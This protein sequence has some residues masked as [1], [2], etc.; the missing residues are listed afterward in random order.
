MDNE[1]TVAAIQGL[2]QD[3]VALSESRLPAVEKLCYDLENNIEAFRTLLEKKPKSEA[4]RNALVAGTRNAPPYYQDPA[5]TD[6]IRQGT[7]R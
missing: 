7:D 6:L 3:L 2:H 4:S 5:A 1:D